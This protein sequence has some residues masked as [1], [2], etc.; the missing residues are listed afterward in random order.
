MPNI[1]FRSHYNLTNQNQ[2]SNVDSYRFNSTQT[3][4]INVPGLNILDNIQNMPS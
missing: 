4:M 1:H 2:L 3:V